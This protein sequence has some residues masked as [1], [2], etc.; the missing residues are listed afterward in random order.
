MRRQHAFTPSLLAL[1]ISGALGGPALAQ[2]PIEDAP[3]LTEDTVLVQGKA[4]RHT[5]TKSALA[6]EKTPQGISVVDRETLDQRSMDSV[7]EALRY[8]P[9]VHTELRGGAV[10]RLD[11]FN[12]RGFINYQ[13][14]YDGLPLTYNDWNL[15]PQIDAFA[16]EQVDV[17][18]GP[19]SVLY[20]AM[21]PGGM[22]NLIA[23]QPSNQP[24]HELTLSGGSHDLREGSFESR[25][26]LRD[27]GSL[28]YSLV[29]LGR[30]QDG[31][32]E[33]SEEE[34]YLIAPA[35]DWHISDRTLLNLNL[36]Y[37]QDPSAGIYTTLPASGLFKDNVNG[38]LPA[39][40]YSGD[41]NWNTYDREVLMLGY[42]LNHELNDDWTLLQNLRFMD[43]SAYQENSYGMGLGADQRTLT[44]RAYLTDEASRSWA[45]DNQLSG[46]LRS[47]ALEHNL[48]LG[49][50]YTRLNSD[51]RYEDGEIPAIDLFAPDNHLVRPGDI[52]FSS[53]YS[54][55]FRLSTRQAGFYLQDQVRLDRLVLIAGGR[56]D[57]YQGKEQGR[58][59]GARADNMV[60][61]DKFSF[62]VGAL[63]E[64]PGGFSPF[65]SYAEGFEPITGQDRH[66]KT[67]D[68]T[69]S[70][71]WEAGVKYQSADRR[72][73]GTLS[74]FHIT[75]QNEPTRDPNGS[76]YDKTQ[77]GEVQAKGL[78]LEAKSYLT[79]NLSLAASLTLM[80]MAFSKDESGELLGKTPVWVPERQASLWANYDLFEGALAGTALGV[81]VRYVGKTQMDTLNTDQVPAYTLVDLALGY[82][83]GY[84]NADWDGARL[85]LSA[86][87]LF[88]KRY[89]SCFDDSNCWFGA[90]RELKAS[91]SYRF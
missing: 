31:Q 69:T 12:I 47:G 74:A 76:P 64:L 28:N 9:G 37:Q 4:Y 67:F 13:N 17:F 58:K 33:T 60:E 51:I 27:D 68:P 24:F 39:D 75:K 6:P 22:V 73:Q 3:L 38:R 2:P 56:Y 61:Q 91:L 53:S 80:D 8:V 23:K 84:L 42:K 89:Y 82:D 5:A 57:R 55:D 19:T 29:A 35:L 81:G 87:N 21:P 54:S 44:R 72:H 34:R 26:A 30:K 77:A 36:Y 88:D 10:G 70:Q 41:A 85:Q 16:L 40:I 48:L 63:Y 25:G 52:A 45:I 50:D 62:R 20:G 78:E 65:V 59:Y 46:R 66:G 14:F 18:K 15:Q 71:Q 32:A 86:S 79:D 83:L 11:L 90:E 1:A 7:A 49:V 43:A